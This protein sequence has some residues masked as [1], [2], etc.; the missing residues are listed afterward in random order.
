LKEDSHVAL[1]ILAAALAT[2]GIILVQL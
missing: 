2:L 1:K